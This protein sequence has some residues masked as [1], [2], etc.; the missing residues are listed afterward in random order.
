MIPGRRIVSVHGLRAGTI[1]KVVPVADGEQLS[2]D[3]TRGSRL[4][5]ADADLGQY[6]GGF[7]RLRSGRAE[8]R[9]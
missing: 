5:D 6:L 2:T 7:E 8:L 1:E 4:G 9:C 3:R